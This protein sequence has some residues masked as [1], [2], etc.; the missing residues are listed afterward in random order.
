MMNACLSV[1]GLTCLAIPARRVARRTIRA[2]P[3][4]PS[5]PPVRSDEQRPFGAL[6][7]GQVDGAGG[8]RRER[9]GGH[10]AAL[11]GDDQGAVAALQSQL[12]EVCAGGLGHPQPVQR[13]QGDQRV[14]GGR[15]EAGGDQERAEP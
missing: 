2:V 11:A 12:L 10:L 5:P 6:S 14:L 8:A 9:D 3:W 4:R 1:W 7:H 15:A 13:Q